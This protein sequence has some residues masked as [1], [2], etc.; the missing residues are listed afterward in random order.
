MTSVFW[1]AKG[2]LLIDY[3]EK[4][5]TI[6][7]EYYYNLLEQMDA[8][9]REKRPGLWKKKSS[10]TRTTHLITKVCWQW[11]TAEFENV[12]AFVITTGSTTQWQA[13]LAPKEMAASD[14]RNR[15]HVQ[16]LPTWSTK[17]L[18]LYPLIRSPYRVLSA[19]PAEL[20]FFSELVT[21][22]PLP[23]S[24][25]LGTGKGGVPCDVM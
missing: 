25:E 1:D 16:P 3:H 12:S 11:E 21:A 20:R 23:F 5:R 18:I 9:I 8:K 19:G 15:R 24:S 2:I 7:G 6:T 4:G 13:D 22:P 17:L 14:M 10:F